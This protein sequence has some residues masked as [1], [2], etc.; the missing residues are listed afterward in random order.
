MRKYDIV[1]AIDPDVTKSGV[2]NLEVKS[3]SLECFALTFPELMDYLL[4][5]KMEEEERKFLSGFSHMKKRILVVVEAGYLN[6]SNW[7]T[8]AGFNSATTAKIGNNTGRNH[9]VARK[10]V[11]VAKHYGF[12]VKEAKPLKKIWG[13]HDKKI[14]HKELAL[15]TGISG[16]TTQDMRDAGLLAWTFAGLPI[17]ISNQ[18]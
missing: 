9:E 1:I 11:E 12:E 16:R 8:K 17:K 4:A 18:K 14:T 7:H 5:F 10:I 13:G 3:K 15:F 2:A 6:R